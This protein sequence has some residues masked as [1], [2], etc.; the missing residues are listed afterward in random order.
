M[1]NFIRAKDLLF[2]LFQI[3]GPR[4][5]DSKTTSQMLQNYLR[6]YPVLHLVDNPKGLTTKWVSNDLNRLRMISFLNRKREKRPVLGASIEFHRGFQYR[7]RISDGG[8]RYL[9]RMQHA[10]FKLISRTQYSSETQI[11][12]Q[13][14][15]LEATHIE[16]A[17][18]RHLLR[19]GKGLVPF[20]SPAIYAL[21]PWQRQL[22][23]TR[24][25]YIHRRGLGFG[26][27][28]GIYEQIVDRDLHI[29]WLREQLAKEKDRNRRLRKKVRFHLMSDF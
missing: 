29:Q 6:K 13:A 8:L 4:S 7:Y 15:M 9:A 26:E 3:F 16:K 22:Y 20:V 11:F 14:E 18:Y 25:D 21:E 12:L 23:L 10:G 1:T 5:F 28:Y 2:T 19:I 17:A 27:R 24:E